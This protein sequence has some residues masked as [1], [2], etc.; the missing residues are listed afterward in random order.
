ARRVSTLIGATRDRCPT[1]T[2]LLLLVTE[3]FSEVAATPSGSPAASPEG[4]D[5]CGSPGQQIA[6]E[7]A[8]ARWLTGVV[9]LRE[10]PSTEEDHARR[11]SWGSRQ[12]DLAGSGGGTPQGTTSIFRCRSSAISPEKLDLVVRPESEPL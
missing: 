5:C 6:R 9:T 11:R 10:P 8:A 2:C 7:L 3:G 1:E 4:A 12:G